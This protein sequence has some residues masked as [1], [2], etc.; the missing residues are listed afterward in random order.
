ME[1]RICLSFYSLFLVLTFVLMQV[2]HILLAW[3]PPSSMNPLLLLHCKVLRR[4]HMLVIAYY[5]VP[6][7][8]SF[9]FSR[10]I[11]DKSNKGTPHARGR[12]RVC[13]LGCCGSHKISLLPPQHAASVSRV[14]AMA[15]IFGVHRSLSHQLPF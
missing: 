6:Q 7:V 8:A 14:L 3:V 9:I 10:V 13:A 11:S 1:V 4:L 12:I 2:I 5:G 15:S